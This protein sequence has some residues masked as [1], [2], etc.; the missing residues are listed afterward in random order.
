MRACGLER[1][2][3]REL[4]VECPISRQVAQMLEVA[5]AEAFELTRVGTPLDGVGANRLEHDVAVADTLNETLVHQRG[6][7]V[8][9]LDATERLAGN[10]RLG[11]V[12]REGADE[13]RQPS[14]RET[15][16]LVQQVMAP[17]D[18]REQRSL[19]FQRPRARSQ[20]A[21][22]VVQAPHQIVERHRAQPRRRQ[23]DGQRNTVETPADRTNRSQSDR[24]PR[25]TS[26]LE[27][28]ARSQNSTIALA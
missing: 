3:G 16:R 20:D 17:V 4:I 28:F 6:D 2:R 18:R 25:R 8:E 27:V 23:L 15:F 14:K 9:H 10:D 22:T 26:G 12:E 5:I 11:V 21:E 13:H 24:R 7:Q 1:G 19:A